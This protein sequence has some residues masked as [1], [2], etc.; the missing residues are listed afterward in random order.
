MGI[1]ARDFYDETKIAIVPMGFCFPG[2]NDK[3][4]DLPPRRECARL[5]HRKL[6]A[7]LPN[8]ELILVIGIYAQKW[9]LGSY[10]KSNLTETVRHWKDYLTLKPSPAYLPLPHPSWRNN[11]WLKQNPWFAFEVLP[12]L[13]N[14]IRRLC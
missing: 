8:L 1:M 10:C 13:K 7:G 2:L 9:H 12:F 4:G 6:F 5:W 3:G 11:N 14:E